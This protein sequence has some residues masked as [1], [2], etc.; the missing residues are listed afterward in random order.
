[1]RNYSERGE[2]FTERFLKLSIN[3]VP[4]NNRVEE[5]THKFYTPND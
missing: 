1:M 3:L 4:I 2:N 5:I